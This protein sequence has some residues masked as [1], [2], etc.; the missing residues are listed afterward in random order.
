MSRGL[1]Q[2]QKAILRIGLEKSDSGQGKIGV[3]ARD[4]LIDHYGFPFIRSPK[5]LGRGKMVF[6]K[7]DI[8]QKRYASATVTV[9]QCF[10]RLIKRGLAERLDRGNGFKLSHDG[11]KLA[12]MIG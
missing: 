2:I 5:A 10:N 4:I 11:I 1:G 12:K 3:L 6:R 9:C 8:G 7:A